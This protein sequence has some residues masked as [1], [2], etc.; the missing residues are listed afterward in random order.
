M[1]QRDIHILL[2]NKNVHCTAAK[3]H[4]VVPE[5]NG[6][7]ILRIFYI[8]NNTYKHACI[9]PTIIPIMKG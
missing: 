3:S 7:C 6:M 9:N 4:A 8:S 5:V 2:V 1:Y